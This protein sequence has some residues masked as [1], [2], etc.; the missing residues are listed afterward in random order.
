MLQSSEWHTS[1]SPRPKKSRATKFNIKV[2][3]VAFVDDEGIVHSEFVPTE[4][5]VTA[6]VYVDVL[7]GVRESVR[8]KR[9]Q[10]WKNDWALQHDNAPSHMDMAVQELLAGNNIQIVPH[11]PYW[12][13]L[14]PSGFWLFPTP[15]TGLR[16]RRF[17]TVEDIKENADARVRAIKKKILSMLRQL[18]RQI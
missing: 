17:A 10:K 15:K 14:G 16:K 12:P 13:D 1:T 4:T 5:S 11:P 9:P 6:A 3:L 8:P 18:D 2:I 7:T